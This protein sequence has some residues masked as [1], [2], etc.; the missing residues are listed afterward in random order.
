MDHGTTELYG[1]TVTVLPA[2]PTPQYPPLSLGYVESIHAC[3]GPTDTVKIYP[4]H[5]SRT[6]CGRIL[7]TSFDKQQVQSDPT[8]TIHPFIDRQEDQ[9]PPC[10]FKVQL[11]LL[12]Y[13]SPHDILSNWPPTS[14]SLSESI[15]LAAPSNCVVWVHSSQVGSIIY[16]PHTDDCSSQIFG[17]LSGRQD[18]YQVD[19][20]II[21]TFARSR[22]RVSFNQLDSTG[23][24][25]YNM[26]GYPRRNTIRGYT[27]FTERMFEAISNVTKAADTMLTKMGS[28]NSQVTKKLSIPFESYRHIYNV[29]NSE[30][31]RKL[32]FNTDKKFKSKVRITT[33]NMTLSVGR[34]ISTKW[35]ITARN[36]EGFESLRSVIGR[37]GYGVK[38]KHPNLSAINA[39]DGSNRMSV[40]EQDLIHIVDLNEHNILYANATEDSDIGSSAR[41]PTSNCIRMTYDSGSRQ[42]TLTIKC[43][44]TLVSLLS[45]DSRLYL[46]NNNVVTGVVYVMHQNRVW[47]VIRVCKDTDSSLMC[48]PDDESQTMWLD[49]DD[50]AANEIRM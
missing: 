24:G 21:I 8:C 41:R 35:T 3:L 34:Q 29:L 15:S 19:H 25:S 44:S 45:S 36:I 13:L 9:H 7:L 37:I 27:S 12:K 46:Q 2:I 47:K 50:V 48:D 22:R 40:Q 31:N 18:L 5:G 20:E 42:L 43:Y 30:H 1:I 17:N 10:Y 6:F 14:I 38:K 33:D 32:H 16:F 11:F 4:S 23:D 26:F 49:N 39:T 28:V